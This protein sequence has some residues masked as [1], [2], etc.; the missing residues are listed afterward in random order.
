VLVEKRAVQ[1][2]RNAVGLRA[3][4]PAGAVLDF[5]EL[6][7]QLVGVL[8]GP[9]AVGRA[10]ENGDGDAAAQREREIERLHAKIGELIV[11]S[12]NQVRCADITYIPI[13]RGFLNL[14]AIMDWASRAVLSWR[15]SNSMH[16]SFAVTALEEALARL[17]RPEISTRAASLPAPPHSPACCSLRRTRLDRRRFSHVYYPI[18]VDFGCGSGQTVLLGLRHGIEIYGVDAFDREWNA[19]REH[20]V[21]DAASRIAIIGTESVSHLVPHSGRCHP[22]YGQ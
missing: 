8:V 18:V 11:E 14:V 6:Q 2:V 21:P 3:L 12:P 7:E 16:S 19:W 17:G 20:L 13:G 1:R 4:D 5:L 10:F 15:L 9:R 22:A